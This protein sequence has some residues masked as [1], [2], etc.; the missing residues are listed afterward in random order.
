M[1]TA[2]MTTAE[3]AAHLRLSTRTLD[4]WREKR[5]GPRFYRLG[6]KVRYSVADLN[7]WVKAQ[8]VEPKGL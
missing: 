6:G 2:Q 4:L 5:R 3:A 7:A 8:V 1:T